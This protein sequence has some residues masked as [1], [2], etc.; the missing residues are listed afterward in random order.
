MPTL[1]PKLTAVRDEAVAVVGTCVSEDGE[2]AHRSL[3][4]RRRTRGVDRDRAEPC[5]QPRN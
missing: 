4:Q 5:N 3:A 1:G 2:A